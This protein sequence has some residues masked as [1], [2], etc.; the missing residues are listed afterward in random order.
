MELTARRLEPPEWPEAAR[1]MARSLQESLTEVFPDDPTQRVV[2]L[3]DRFEALP[4]K[5]GVAVGAFGGRHLLGAARAV[6]YA[7]CMCRA[8]LPADAQQSSRDYQAFLLA[9][10][11]NRPHWF[12]GPVG[13]EPGLQRA[14]IG[15]LAMEEL[16]RSITGA[17]MV[18]VEA[19]DH[20]V[21]FYERV[22]FRPTLRAPA[23][24]GV[25]ITFLEAHV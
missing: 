2:L 14:G 15:T 19:E 3:Y 21:G 23:P 11:P 17:G 6:P 8:E 13:V 9:N 5:G 25:P 1:L 4:T 24:D 16:M 22:G 7:S 10:H 12:V 20:N 18:C